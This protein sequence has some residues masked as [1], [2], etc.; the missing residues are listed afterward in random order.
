MWLPSLISLSFQLILR[1]GTRFI[2]IPFSTVPSPLPSLNKNALSLGLSQASL[3][4]LI[5]VILQMK[6]KEFMSTPEVVSGTCVHPTG[7][8]GTASEKGLWILKSR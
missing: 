3:N 4:I 2:T 7:G 6:V 1:T 8:E 5:D